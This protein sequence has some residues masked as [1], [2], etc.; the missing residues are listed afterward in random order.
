M[1]LDAYVNGMKEKQDSIYYMSGDSIATMQ[2]SPA[3]QM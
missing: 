2:K 3:L 1:S